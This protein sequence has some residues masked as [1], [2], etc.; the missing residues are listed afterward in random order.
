[1]TYFYRLLLLL[2]MALTQRGN[3]NGATTM[4]GNILDSIYK[5]TQAEFA[6][7]DSL[8]RLVAAPL[9]K[10][11]HLEEYAQSLCCAVLL[12]W[13]ISL[14]KM[15][16]KI[17]L[18]WLELFYLFKQLP[19]FILPPSFSNSLL[20]LCKT[21]V[22]AANASSTFMEERS[23]IH[24]S[25]EN[26]DVESSQSIF[27]KMASLFFDPSVLTAKPKEGGEGADEEANVFIQVAAESKQ[28]LHNH[29]TAY[30]TGSPR[31]AASGLSINS[32]ADKFPTLHAL[33]PAFKL[34]RVE[35]FCLT[36]EQRSEAI[37]SVSQGFIKFINN[38][39][40]EAAHILNSQHHLLK[41]LGF[42]QLEKFVLDQTLVEA[43]M[44]AED[45]YS[46]RS[47]LNERVGLHVSDGQAWIR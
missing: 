25:H 38:D 12:G 32:L 3:N 36:P 35:G 27:G 6:E 22:F 17:R 1:V 10:C 18:R 4:L 37:R 8:S 23:P 16:L 43:Y 21:I 42:T 45:W 47:L 31:S 33:P 15:N 5:E 11:K 14:H 39:F 40:A 28:M 20:E 29:L 9:V 26:D 41:L 46:A 2:G 7:S 34:N 24:L 13:Q 19:E 44:C 30:E